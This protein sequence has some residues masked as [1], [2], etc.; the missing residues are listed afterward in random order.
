MAVMA[1]ILYSDRDNFSYFCYTG[2]PDA[3]YLDSSQ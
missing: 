3:S 2:H 1:A